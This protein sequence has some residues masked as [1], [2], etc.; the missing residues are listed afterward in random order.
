MDDALRIIEAISAEPVHDLRE[1]LVKFDAVWW[2]TKEDANVL[3]SNTL[4][5]LARFRRSLRGLARDR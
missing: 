4:R 2:W 1:L 5:W 3:D